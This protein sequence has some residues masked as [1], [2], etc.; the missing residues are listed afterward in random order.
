M[1]A[2]LRL[3]D[4]EERRLSLSKLD[5]AQEEARGLGRSDID[6]DLPAPEAYAKLAPAR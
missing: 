6:A 4:T 1:L 3:N 2:V 5:A